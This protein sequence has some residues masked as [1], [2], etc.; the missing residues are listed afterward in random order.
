[1]R[2][3]QSWQDLS[4]VKCIQD[5][6]ERAC[7]YRLHGPSAGGIFAL[8]GGNQPQVP[9]P[10]ESRRQPTEARRDAGVRLR[11]RVIVATVLFLFSF[12]VPLYAQWYKGNTHTHTINSGG[13]STPDDVARWYRENGYDFLV[14]TDHDMVTDV[15]PLNAIFGGGG[16]FLVIRGEEVTSDFAGPAGEIFVHVNSLNPREAARPAQGASA[17]DTLQKDLDAIR[18]AGGLAQINHPNFMWQLSASDIAAAKGARLME[19]MNMHPL[20]NSFGAGQAFPGTEELWD[21]VLSRGLLIWGVASD[22]TH[23]IKS[24]VSGKPGK[25]W[26]VVRAQHL[27]ADEILQA[28]DKG[29]FYAS[30]GVELKDYKVED[31]QITL[32]VRGQDRYKMK[33]RTQFIGKDGKVLQDGTANPAVYLIKG[34][35]GYVR[36]RITDSQG[37]MAWTQ[38]V[39]VRQEHPDQ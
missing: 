1:M 18:A 31:K 39:F 30:T 15:A 27:T 20:V 23:D 29:D 17:G 36:A 22:D 35:E 4:Y 14:I 24:G 28:I 25:G 10:V 21:Q 34:N 9:H 5:T 13:D 32:E 26:I 7:D 3:E 12:P 33:Y 2:R 38:P 16:Q 37:S 19:I 11:K 8:I 6:S